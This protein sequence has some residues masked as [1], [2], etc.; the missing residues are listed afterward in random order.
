MDDEDQ[1]WQDEI[2]RRARHYNDIAERNG[3]QGR[4]TATDY[5]AL[6]ALVGVL[7]VGFWTWGN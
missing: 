4:M 6:V 5:L 2:E 3:W 1:A 7:V